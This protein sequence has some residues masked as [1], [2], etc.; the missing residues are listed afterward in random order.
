MWSTGMG[1]I[2]SLYFLPE[3]IGHFKSFDKLILAYLV[4][5]VH[6]GIC[7]LFLWLGISCFYDMR[8]IMYIN[9]MYSLVMI[10]FAFYKR[11]VLTLLYNHIL[12][13]PAC[14]RYIPIWQRILDVLFYEPMKNQ[15]RHD[16][17]H[18]YL[19]LNDHIVQSF[20]MLMINTFGIWKMKKKNDNIQFIPKQKTK[21]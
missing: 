19:W 7:I 1:M 12:D 11:C 3:I 4:Q 17:N 21:C 8:Y 20:F 6:D 2:T 10:C 13:L 15:C 16:V 14:N 5:G 18:T 9:T